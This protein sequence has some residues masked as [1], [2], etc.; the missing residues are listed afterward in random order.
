MILYRL[1]GAIAI[2]LLCF[3]GRAVAQTSTSERLGNRFPAGSID[4]IAKADAALAAAGAAKA[5]VESDYKAAASVCLG[6]FLVND[7]VEEARHAR[8]TRLAGIEA[9][10]VEAN[11]YKRREHGDRLAAER[12]KLEAERKAN[13]PSDARAREQNRAAF[14]KKQEDAKKDAKRAETK[15]TRGAATRAEG[16]GDRSSVIA[17]KRKAPGS[18]GSQRAKNAAEQTEKVREAVEHRDKLAKR[19]AR[20]EADRARRAKE[21]AEKSG[22]PLLTAP[23]STAT[24]PR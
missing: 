14:E 3:A 5:R 13:A 19:R 12:A 2:A 6:T 18:D 15:S 10:E 23:A 21:Q 9:V 17:P 8:R 1:S 16:S 7:C 11:R 4:S 20:K 24:P 22:A